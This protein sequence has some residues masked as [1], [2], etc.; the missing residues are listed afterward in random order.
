M[1]EMPDVLYFLGFLLHILAVNFKEIVIKNARNPNQ[2]AG[3]DGW[4]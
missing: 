2:V 4:L 3:I 1:P